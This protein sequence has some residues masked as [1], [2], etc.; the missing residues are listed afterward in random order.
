MESCNFRY[1]IIFW[2]SYVELQTRRLSCTLKILYPRWTH[3]DLWKIYGNDLIPLGKIHWRVVPHA[4][5]CGCKLSLHFFFARCWRLLENIG[6]TLNLLTNLVA[7]LRR[8]P[9]VATTLFFE[10]MQHLLKLAISLKKLKDKFKCEEL[11]FIWHEILFEEMWRLMCEVSIL[12][13]VWW[14]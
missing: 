1:V 2:N 12:L 4:M 8:T 3:E 5:E 13:H 7:A 9:W 10:E 11:M 14:M 6:E